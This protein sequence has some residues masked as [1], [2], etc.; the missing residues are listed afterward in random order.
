MAISDAENSFCRSMA[1][2]P[3]TWRGLMSESADS[4]LEANLASK[5]LWP[6]EMTV[7]C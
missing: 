1:P 6:A 7:R 5:A 4:R 2:V 3:M